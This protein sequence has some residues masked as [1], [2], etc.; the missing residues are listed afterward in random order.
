MRRIWMGLIILA[1]GC[2]PKQR[3]ISI[4]HEEWPTE[5]ELKAINAINPAQGL[6]KEQA[7]W[8]AKLY[9]EYVYGGCGAMR[10]GEEQGNEWVFQ[11]FVG[12]APARRA[13]IRVDRSTGGIQCDGKQSFDSPQAFVRHLLTSH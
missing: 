6:T 12:Y 2:L 7:R 5:S 11:C 1:L 8:V 9:F 3:A 4:S 13:P 10:E